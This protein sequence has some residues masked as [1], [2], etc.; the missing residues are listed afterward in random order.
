MRI[1]VGW[2]DGAG[3]AR[4]PDLSLSIAQP[5]LRKFSGPGR[6]TSITGLVRIP[7]PVLEQPDSLFP[8]GAAGDKPGRPAQ[9]GL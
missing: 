1:F 6:R 5:N 7:D 9:P 4:G 2:V 3:A 8:A